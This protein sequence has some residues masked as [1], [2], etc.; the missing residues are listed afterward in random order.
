MKI[1]ID[2]PEYTSSLASGYIDGE[3]LEVF[4]D[5][6]GEVGIFGNKEGLTSLAVNL[7]ALAQENV[8]H[9]YHQHFSRDYGLSEDSVDLVVGKL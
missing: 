9:G 1:T 6:G 8:P 7:L 4:I 3:H 2:I 5:S